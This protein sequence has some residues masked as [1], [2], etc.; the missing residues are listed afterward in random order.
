MGEGERNFYFLIFPFLLM[1]MLHNQI[2]I[3][4][5]CYRTA[6]GKNRIVDK[7]LEFEQVDRESNWDDQILFNGALFYIGYMI[8]PQ[9]QKAPLWSTNGVVMTILLH[10]G[11]SIASSLPLLSLS[12]PPPF[13]HCHRAYFMCLM[14][15]IPSGNTFNE[16]DNK[17]VVDE[18]ASMKLQ[19][20]GI[21][22]YSG[23]VEKPKIVDGD[24]DDVSTKMAQ[25]VCSLT[26]RE[27]CIACGS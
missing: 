27:E 20:L 22:P 1:R 2:W 4:I 17:L 8:F 13:L 14:D 16:V 26:N 7:G 5:S 21:F 18:I 3:S 9:A 19:Y 23:L 10:A 15:L 25:M 24:D 11:P 6:K 12:F